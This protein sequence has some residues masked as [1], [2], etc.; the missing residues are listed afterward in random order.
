MAC[1]ESSDATQINAGPG[2]PRWHASAIQVL[3]WRRFP[4]AIGR[5]QQIALRV[6]HE[7]P[8][9]FGS[10]SVSLGKTK[11][12]IPLGTAQLFYCQR[13]DLDGRAVLAKRHLTK[14]DTGPGLEKWLSLNAEYAK[15]WPNIMVKKAPPPDS[16]DSGGKP[17]KLQYFSPNPGAGD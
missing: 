12:A 6:F 5:A 16:K 15:S 3:T 9:N 4:I 13:A 11:S 17:D 10:V 2:R 1:A 8:K 7:L 14:P